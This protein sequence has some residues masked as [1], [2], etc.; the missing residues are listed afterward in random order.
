VDFLHLADRASL[1]D[2]RGHAIVGGGMNLDAHLRDN[3]LLLGQLGHAA[4]FVQAVGER[5]LAVDVLAES[6]RADTHRR[7]HVVGCGNVHTVDLVGFL[8]QHLAPVLIEARVGE[9]LASRGGLCEVHI[10]ERRDLDVLA[11]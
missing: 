5:L 10:A 7:V 1:D 9:F 6:H 2:L 8:L 4:D 11:I 3:F